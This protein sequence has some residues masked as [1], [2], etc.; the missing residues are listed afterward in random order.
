MSYCTTVIFLIKDKTFMLSKSRLESVY[1]IGSHMFDIRKLWHCRNTFTIRSYKL[2][3]EEWKKRR[4]WITRVKC[5]THKPNP[6]CC[7]FW[8][9]VFMFLQ[10]N[11]MNEYRWLYSSCFITNLMFYR[12]REV[13]HMAKATNGHTDDIC[14]RVNFFN[15]VANFKIE[16]KPHIF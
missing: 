13:Y 2:P 1:Q 3:R 15:Q 14:F 9:D 5:A 10:C 16:K 11:D 6:T 4:S 7:A 8:E 12:Y